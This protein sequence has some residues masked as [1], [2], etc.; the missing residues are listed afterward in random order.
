MKNKKKT[1]FTQISNICISDKNLSLDARGL[2]SILMSYPNDWQFYNQN[3]SKIANVGVDKLNKLYKQLEMYGY[4]KRTK[5]RDS[6]GKFRGFE[7]KICDQGSFK[8]TTESSTE[9]TPLWQK[10]VL[11][12]SVAAKSVSTNINL[13]NT[14]NDDYQDKMYE[15]NQKLLQKQ[16]NKD[17]QIQKLENLSVSTQNK[18]DF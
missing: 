7:F 9:K 13:T 8:M 6:K 10:S 17:I 4:I 12:M 5:K 3:I 14:N 16:L 15:L 11:D 1:N 18:I 2:M